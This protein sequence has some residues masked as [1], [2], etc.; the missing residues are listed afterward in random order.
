M[1]DRRHR[2][3]WR[4]ERRT[5]LL[6]VGSFALAIAVTLG[7]LGATQWNG[8]Y[9]AHLRPVAVVD[10]TAFDGD[11]LGTRV[12]ILLT[13]LAVDAE[14][15]QAQGDPNDPLLEQQLNFL[16]QQAQRVETDA[17]DRIVNGAVHRQQ[18]PALGIAVSEAEIDT[19]IASRATSPAAVRLRIIALDAATEGDADAR[20]EAFEETE[21]RAREI[22]GRIEA[23]EDFATVATAESTDDSAQRGGDIGFVTA[24]DARFADLFAA[25]EGVADGELVGPVRTSTGYT[26]A[27]VED[28]R[29]EERDP[30]YVARFEQNGVER[31]EYRAHVEEDLLDDR[32]RAHFEEKVVVSPQEQRRVAQIFIAEPAAES[33]GSEQRVR[34][35]LVQ[36]LPGEQ[37]QAAAT[38]EQWAEALD[39]AQRVR[40][41]LL[42]PNA[43]W[44][45]IAPLE[46]GDPGSAQRGGDLGWSSVEAPPYVPEFVDALASLEIGELSEP[47]RSQFGYHLIEITDERES[48]AAQVESI[49]A[50]LADDPTAF[51]DLAR[52]VSDDFETS[53][54]GGEI[55][56]VA[57]YELEPEKESVIFAL[58]E[59][60]SVS[61][62]LVIPGDGTYILQLLEIDP[63]REVEDDRLAQIRQNG[64]ERWQ[65][66][67]RDR[68]EIWI[69]PQ[70]EAAPAPAAG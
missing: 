18:A 62:P 30:D 25:S 52:R 49:V 27:R 14:R 19:E 10:G 63:E 31:D 43:D 33:T 23:G 56:W 35:I 59:E 7:I 38:E 3:R 8:Y 39:R 44:S 5:Q 6:L 48:A 17:V 46:S 36:P 50:E 22:M 34:H 51:G 45:V 29:A 57:R 68:A 69:D 24:R 12:T 41:E 42:K 60:G 26:I 40:A 11:D 37:D 21:A 47:V 70:F 64:Y 28:R 13:E 67:M 54:R 1:L 20:E 55:G 16:D 53:A 15:L 61:D 32:F 9:D 2:P 65:T 4:E 58:A 66:E